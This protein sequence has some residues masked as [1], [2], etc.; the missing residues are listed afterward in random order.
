MFTKDTIVDDISTKEAMVYDW[1]VDNEY[2]FEGG[3][4]GNRVLSDWDEDIRFVKWVCPVN[5]G[6]FK[7]E[8]CWQPQGVQ[9]GMF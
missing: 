1:P 8:T 5:R 7:Q 2:N 4:G 3:G 6:P 9:Q